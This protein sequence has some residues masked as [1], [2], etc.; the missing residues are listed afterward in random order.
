MIRSLEGI[1]LDKPQIYEPLPREMFDRV[2]QLN[3]LNYDNSSIAVWERGSEPESELEEILQ[4]MIGAVQ[5]AIPDVEGMNIEAFT[6]RVP[7][8]SVQI[9]AASPWHWDGTVRYMMA[10]NNLMTKVLYVPSELPEGTRDEALEVINAAQR[11]MYNFE[12]SMIENG[13]RLGIFAVAQ[14]AKYG[15]I[16]MNG[17]IHR[18]TSNTSGEMT[19]R[20]FIRAEIFRSHS[21]SPSSR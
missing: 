17:M 19:D 8:G 18:A 15:M 9:D 20:T 14:A 4:P 3:S 21:L 7:A 13:I 1:N 2:L 12:Q 11:N 5:E 6:N 10:T 16:D